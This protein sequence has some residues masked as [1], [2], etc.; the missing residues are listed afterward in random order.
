MIGSSGTTTIEVAGFE[1]VPLNIVG[2]E[3]EGLPVF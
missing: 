1:G 3:V 2:V